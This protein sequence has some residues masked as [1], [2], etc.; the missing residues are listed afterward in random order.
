[1]QRPI[2]G[3]PLMKKRMNCR[4]ECGGQELLDSVEVLWKELNRIH[5]TKSPYFR[6]DFSSFSFETR[7]R[8]LIAK[9]DRGNLRVTIASDREART[10]GY[11]ISSIEGREGEIESIFVAEESRRDGVGTKLIEDSLDWFHGNSVKRVKVSVVYGNEDVFE[12]YGKFG[13]FPRVTILCSK[14]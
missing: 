11:C 13:L 9:S 4:I 8:D 10:I 3:L 5:E 14:K 7:K 2:P 6:D 12:F 1:M